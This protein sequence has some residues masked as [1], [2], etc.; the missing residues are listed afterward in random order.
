ME[1]ALIISLTV[2][3]IHYT[4]QPGE[5]FGKLGD[6]FDTN[7]PDKLKP[8]VFD[9]PVCMVPWYGTVIYFL[10]V[11]IHHAT[12]GG[13]FVAVIPAMGL[14]AVLVKLFPDKDSEVIQEIK[15]T[16]DEHGIYND[17]DKH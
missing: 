13:W 6:N 2:F 5:I 14:N 10:L 12:F 4:M 8:P 15:S 17:A 7:L 1:F 9:C 11:G 16:L 3:A